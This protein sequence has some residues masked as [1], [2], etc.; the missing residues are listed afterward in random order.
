MITILTPT[1]NRAHTL[2]KLY[3][4][5]VNQTNKGFE[6]LVI[7]DGSTDETKKLIEQL[8]EDGSIDIRYF[9]K[10]NEGKHSALNIG[11]REAKF[12]WI[13]IV[14]SDDWL[15]PNMVDF[16][17][18]ESSKLDVSYNSLSTLRVYE[19]NSVIG[20]K[21]IESRESYIDFSKGKVTGDKADLIRKSAL[22]GFSFPEFKDEN[23]MAEA[24]MYL[25]LGTKGKTKFINYGGYVCK[26]LPGG[27]SD[28]S[29]INRHRCFNSTLFV[30]KSIYKT[31][32][33]FSTK[34][35]KAA[36]NWWRFRLFKKYQNDRFNAPLTYVPLGLA[37][38][39]KDQ[40][41]TILNKQKLID[42]LNK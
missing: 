17:V 26:Y 13:L 20:T 22:Q 25:W 15:K 31:Y 6:W 39:S 10:N 33:F 38:Y 41:L 14:D 28:N 9:K 27:L 5:L 37:M 2:L 4:S 30:Y 11:F 16:L 8:K 42:K 35:H 40:I 18:K 12:E 3:N 23:F 29:I 7:D 1:Y 36:I 32:P 34:K 19:D 21:H 24:P